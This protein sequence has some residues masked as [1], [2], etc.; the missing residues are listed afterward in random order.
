MPL[1][2]G[3]SCDLSILYLFRGSVS[4]A[5]SSICTETNWKNR[6]EKLNDG[7]QFRG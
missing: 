1:D 2:F 5:A 6:T 4:W 7:V 3:E